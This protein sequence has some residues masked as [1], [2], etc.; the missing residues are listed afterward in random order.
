MRAILVGAVE[1]PDRVQKRLLRALKIQAD[2]LLIGVDGGTQCLIRLG[3]KPDFAIGDWDS[4]KKKANILSQVPHLT[5]PKNK[6]RSDLF[7]AGIAAIEAG[8]KEI[9]CLGVTG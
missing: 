4:L 9:L 6:N 2:D 8:A 7:Y 1:V 3:F 5:L